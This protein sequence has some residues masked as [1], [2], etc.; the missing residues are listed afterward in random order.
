MTQDIYY[1]IFGLSLLTLIASQFT[2][3]LDVDAGDS[4][5]PIFSIKNIIS[6]VVGFSATNAIYFGTDNIMAY[7]SLVGFAFILVNFTLLKL[8]TSLN[9]DGTAVSSSIV[10]SNAVVTIKIPPANTGTGKISV[11]LG[12]SL[13]EVEADSSSSDIISI[14]EKVKILDFQN[15]L[16]TVSRIQT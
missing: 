15:D 7:A 11:V 6:F 1:I 4:G 2:G 9:E 13:R 3:F 10:G 14:G 16:F 12:G 5:I 8:M